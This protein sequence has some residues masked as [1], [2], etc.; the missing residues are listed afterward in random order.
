MIIKKVFT[1]LIVT[2][3]FVISSSLA[4]NGSVQDSKIVKNIEPKKESFIDW[5]NLSNPILAMPDRMLKD[6]AVVYHN[7]SFYIFS[8]ARFENND[9]TNKNVF[10]RTQ[11]FKTYEEFFDENIAEG[12]SPDIIHVDDTFYIVFQ[13]AVPS[14]YP[15]MHRL[16]YS[17]STNLINWS[18]PKELAPDIQPYMRHIDGALAYEDGYFYLGYKGW[19][20]F[21]VT[22]SVNKELDGNWLR[23]RWS[24]PG[25][26]FNW[27]ENY[28]F[29]KID[30]IWHMIATSRLT[31]DSILDYFLGLIRRVLHP[32]VASQAPYI[33]TMEGY[34]NC[35]KHW[36]R[37]VNKT[38]LDVPTED[39]NQLMTANSAYLCDWREYDGYFYLFYA[40]TNDWLKFEERG[41][42]KIGVARSKDLVQWHLP[43]D[44]SE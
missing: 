25:G 26:P 28:Q 40:G 30:G 31:Y 32:Y 16:Y 15:K 7:G 1:I 33:Y 8:S 14:W 39:W 34:G 9:S 10:Y 13:K 21:F 17:T 18:Q 22:R 11:D 37:W 42:C 6:Q 29:I 12:G 19:Q 2:F 27:A 38:Y 24:W 4:I 36:T 43:G 44:V 5:I 41:H 35:I 20:T 3:L 23:A